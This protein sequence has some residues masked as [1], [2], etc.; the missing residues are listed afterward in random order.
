MPRVDVVVFDCSALK[1][2]TADAGLNVA[3]IAFRAGV[4]A[5]LADKA[6]RGKRI[7]SLSAHAIAR[8][9]RRPLKSLVAKASDST[10]C[11]EGAA[12]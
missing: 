3:G 9:V 2:A 12:A 1:I 6:L 4:S 8:A 11:R 10:T 7:G 5:S